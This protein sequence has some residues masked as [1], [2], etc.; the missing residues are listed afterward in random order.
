ME[1]APVGIEPHAHGPAAVAVQGL[2]GGHVDRVHV[3]ALLPVH[4]DGDEILVELAR[5]LRI[6]EGLLLHDVAPVAG[7]VA[8]REEDRT[9]G[10]ARL[11]EGLVTPGVPVDRVVGVLAEV[12]AGLGDETIGEMRDL[13]VAVAGA[14]LVTLR[15]R[16]EGG[17]DPGGHLGRER[18]PSGRGDGHVFGHVEPPRRGRRTGFE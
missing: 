16:G 18:D 7:G 13:A 4:L 5:D 2:H 17:G 15:E 11:G 10:A 1:G 6:L 8:H 12:R 9:P 3:G 14:G